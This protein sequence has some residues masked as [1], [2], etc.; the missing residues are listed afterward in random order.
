M[1]ERAVKK[2]LQTFHDWICFAK[3]LQTSI[4]REIRTGHLIRGMLVPQREGAVPGGPSGPP[5]PPC[6]L[7]KYPLPPVQ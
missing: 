3:C 4:L 2:S 5:D 1:G 7:D 6:F